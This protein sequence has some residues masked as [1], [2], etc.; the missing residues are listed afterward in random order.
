MFGNG[1]DKI[2]TTILLQ[3]EALEQ[4]Q[5]EF[6][7]TSTSFSSQKGQKFPN[8]PV[9]LVRLVR[10][11]AQ[12]SDRDLSTDAESYYLSSSSS[13]LEKIF[14]PPQLRVIE[15]QPKERRADDIAVHSLALSKQSV[16]IAVTFLV[17]PKQPFSPIQ[18]LGRLNRKRF[19]TSSINCLP[20]QLPQ[21]YSR[22]QDAEFIEQE[23]I[24]RGV[25]PISPNTKKIFSEN[26]EV[27]VDELSAWKPHIVID[28]YRL[29]EDD[30]Q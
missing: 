8:P 22:R 30:D 29:E 7:T 11:I 15:E 19:L 10:S 3:S 6:A 14:L 21:S 2:M 9:A 16:D 24:W 25:F 20:T 1:R 28:S 12:I 17:Q 26:I 5:E 27:R 13:G 18:R 4:N 23:P